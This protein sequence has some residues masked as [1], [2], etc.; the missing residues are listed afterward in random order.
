MSGNLN[1]SGH[2][3]GENLPSLGSSSEENSQE[4][5]RKSPL[6]SSHARNN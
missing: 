3:G 2:G 4:M 5:V 6:R 1:V